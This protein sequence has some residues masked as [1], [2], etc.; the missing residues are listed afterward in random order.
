MNILYI[1]LQKVKRS[2]CNLL[3]IPAESRDFGLR[4]AFKHIFY[5]IILHWSDSPKIYACKHQLILTYLESDFSEIVSEI[6]S[7]SLVND[8]NPIRKIWV[9]WYQ[10]LE[11]APEIV[12]KCRELLKIT[13]TD[14]YEIIE[15]DGNN[16]SQYC[17]LP[18]FVTKK[19]KEGKISLTEFS[20]ILRTKLLYE[21]GGMWVDS[22]LLVQGKV[23]DKYLDLPFYTIRIHGD[24]PYCV[25]GVRLSTYYQYYKQNNNYVGFLSKLLLA[26]WEK[27]N[28]LME[29][30]LMD[31]FMILLANNNI[32][33]D[34]MLNDVPF[35]NPN[36]HMLRNHI[37]DTF[38]EVE[39][40][41]I[42]SDTHF[43]KMTYKM[44]L[45]K[46]GND[47]KKTNYGHII[48]DL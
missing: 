4:F 25:S 5:K 36:V 24:A 28:V 48:D 7:S 10:G 44:A 38:S 1:H 6:Q 11:K 13:Y 43:F 29:Y 2:L 20:D 46:I 22:T 31:Y 16:Y 23:E 19:V 15:L 40:I 18:D 32:K 12:R 3:E 45:R 14:S 30:L 41:K 33:F 9:F 21:N 27:H 42:T 37:N 39:W 26:Y 8:N 35:T 34:N 17:K 47:G